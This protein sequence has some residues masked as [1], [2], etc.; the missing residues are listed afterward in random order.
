MHVTTGVNICSS[1]AHLL[2]DVESDGPAFR[3]DV[4]G[5][6]DGVD[7]SAGADVQHSLALPKECVADGVPTERDNPA[8]PDGTSASSSSV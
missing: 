1:L 7:P 5:G 3:S 8:A 6:E 2:E 4:P